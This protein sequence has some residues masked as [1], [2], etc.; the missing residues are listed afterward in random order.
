MKNTDKLKKA[1]KR[2]EKKEV[3]NKFNLKEQLEMKKQQKKIG[4][5]PYN[6]LYPEFKDKKK[7]KKNK[8]K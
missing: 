5:C 1:R 2:K 8:I 4:E 3:T 6:K 7:N